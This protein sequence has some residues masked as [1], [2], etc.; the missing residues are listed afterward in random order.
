MMS[1]SLGVTLHA[2]VL[3]LS[4]ICTSCSPM[5]GQFP[6]RES[7]PD[8]LAVVTD[9]ALLSGTAWE[10][11]PLQLRTG[12]EIE[13][14]DIVGDTLFALDST[15]TMHAINLETGTHRWVLSLDRAPTRPPVVGSGY[16]A[17]VARNHVTVATLSSGTVVLE[18]GLEF[19]PSSDVALTFDSLYAGAWGSG[20]RVRSVGL[21]DGW[22][23][24]FFR[25][26]DAIVGRPIV[27]G[28]GADQLAYFAS[29]SG[30]VFALSPL[31]ASASPPAETAWSMRTLG[32][33][34]ADLVSDGDRIY[35]ASEDHALY[36]LNRLSG[37]I[38]W[39]WLDGHVALHTAPTIVGDT[40][41]QP[42]DGVVVAIDKETGEE[43]WRYA[44]VDR[45]L[46]RVGQRDYVKLPGATIAVLDAETGE[47]LSRVS[48]PIF[49]QL[50]ANDAGGKLVFSNGRD[51]VALK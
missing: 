12:A 23:G 38:E 37:S 4:L 47:E 50:V 15:R 46:T 22:N 1:R 10:P 51:I 17:F 42:F 32:P 11:I 40:L 18:R 13:T 36:A 14:L 25:T 19:T 39:K 9:Q 28:S 34:S 21:A 45:Y 44:G 24:W 6:A 26:D 3:G 20:T 27:V 49:D 35:V 43:R 2:S 16:V 31:P 41:Y 7:L 29:R 8:T 30:E 5:H 33:N 48:S